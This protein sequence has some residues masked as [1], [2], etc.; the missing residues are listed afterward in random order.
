VGAA[1]CAYRI[2][3]NEVEVDRW[4]VAAADNPAPK[5]LGSCRANGNLNEGE[6]FAAT[7]YRQGA[8]PDAR[9]PA[10]ECCWD[11]GETAVRWF[12]V[13]AVAAARGEER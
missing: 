6:Q 3:G 2:A 9:S 7:L 8:M 5:N 13:R 4:P 12:C 11:P 10:R 1:K